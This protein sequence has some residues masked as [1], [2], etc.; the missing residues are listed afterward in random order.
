MFAYLV[1]VVKQNNNLYDPLSENIK[2]VMSR[3][4]EN[5][6]VLDIGGW[7]KPFNRADY[8]IDYLPY[9]T[10]GGGGSIGQAIEKFIENTWIQLDICKDRLPFPNKCFDFVYC[11]NILED[12]RD[13]IKV[14]QEIIRVGQS[15]YIESPTIWIECQHGVDDDPLADAYPGFNNHRWL[16][17]VINNKLTFIPKLP[18]LSAK[19]FISPEEKDLYLQNHKM[20]NFGLYWTDRFEIDIVIYPNRDQYIDLIQ[21]YFDTFDYSC[22]KTLYDLTKFESGRNNISRNLPK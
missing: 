21:D 16:V 12:V 1:D 15:G 4:R 22:P 8:V 20:W 5:D 6:S 2:F 3:I 18:I 14:C 7:W 17:Y 19:T 10:R 13:P 11:G 9:A